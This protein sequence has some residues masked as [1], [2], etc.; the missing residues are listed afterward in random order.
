MPMYRSIFWRST[1]AMSLLLLGCASGGG[2]NSS[3][4]GAKKE[5]AE[6]SASGFYKNIGDA[7]LTDL[8][9][10]GKRALDRRNYHVIRQEGPPEVYYE[11]QWL[12]REPFDDERALGVV[13]AQS[14]ILLRARERNTTWA[15]A[16]AYTVDFY[17]ENQ[18]RRQG[19]DFTEIPAT[20]QFSAYARAMASELEND[21]RSGVRS[22]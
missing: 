8:E 5:K 12:A 1:I 10:K 21:F 20:K 19:G 6:A 9:Q 3:G 7:T 2:A 14:R 11:T 4:G 13:Q 18:V 17:V 22:F 15:K 16:T